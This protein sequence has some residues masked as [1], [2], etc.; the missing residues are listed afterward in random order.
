MARGREK[1]DKR[2]E[3]GDLPVF[4]L[5]QLSPAGGD[6]LGVYPGGFLWL[7][8]ELLAYSIVTVSHS[9]SWCESSYPYTYLLRIILIHPL[10][11]L[12]LSSFCQSSLSHPHPSKTQG[13]FLSPHSRTV[14]NSENSS[15]HSQPYRKC[16]HLTPPPPLLPHLSEN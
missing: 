15:D 7:G 6:R 12:P 1:R 3:A 10:S 8:E 5:V 16:R 2:G 14:P 11:P 13:K 9:T 4:R